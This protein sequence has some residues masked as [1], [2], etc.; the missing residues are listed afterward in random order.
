MLGYLF[1]GSLY[2][3]AMFVM[4]IIFTALFESVK[5]TI[6]EEGGKSNVFNILFFTIIIIV[7]LAL[8]IK[9]LPFIAK[10]SLICI[11]IGVTILILLF[12]YEFIKELIKK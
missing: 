10:A 2:A 3:L 1:R 11:G 5:E 4:I 6:E 7:M 9:L 8:L 12:I